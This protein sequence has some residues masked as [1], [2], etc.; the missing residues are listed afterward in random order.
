ME[1]NCSTN[2]EL[3][4]HNSGNL[5]NKVNVILEKTMF[6]YKDLAKWIDNSKMRLER[7]LYIKNNMKDNIKSTEKG[8]LDHS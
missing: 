6:C 7:T 5:E 2:R 3:G 1:S 4:V 8:S